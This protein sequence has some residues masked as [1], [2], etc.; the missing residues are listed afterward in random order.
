M[1][2]FIPD[3]FYVC[4]IR[5]RRL[6]VNSKLIPYFLLARLVSCFPFVSYMGLLYEVGEILGIVRD[7]LLLNPKENLSVKQ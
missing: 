5:L 3:W 2:L 6:A 4:F 1:F 7:M